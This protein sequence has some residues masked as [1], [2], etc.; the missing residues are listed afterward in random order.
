MISM[1]LAEALLPYFRGGTCRVFAAPMDVKLS[2]EDV[3]QPDLLVVCRPE[4]IR[5]AYI[6]GAPRLVV[7]ILVR[8]SAP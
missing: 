1:S 4:Q 5:Q 2:E 3:V 7:E 6:D 8:M